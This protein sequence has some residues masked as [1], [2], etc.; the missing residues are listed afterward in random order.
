MQRGRG[1]KTQGAQ[2]YHPWRCLPVREQIFSGFLVHIV[3]IQ[4]STPK[5]RHTDGC[6]DSIISIRLIV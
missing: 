5:T 3:Y 1:K 2:L 6:M 4:A